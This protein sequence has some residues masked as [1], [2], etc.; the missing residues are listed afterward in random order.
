MKKVALCRVFAALSM[1]IVEEITNSARKLIKCTVIAAYTMSFSVNPSV[2]GTINT[3]A[4]TYIN[5]TLI[6]AFTRPTLV[7][8]GGASKA[9]KRPMT[10]P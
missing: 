2:N 10:V 8:K 9:E 3:K 4:K 5:I 7:I 6:K 1:I